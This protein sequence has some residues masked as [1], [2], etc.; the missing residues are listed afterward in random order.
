MDLNPVL[1]RPRP[2]ID[3]QYIWCHWP[4]FSDLPSLPIVS[5]KAKL[6]CWKYH[7]NYFII[8][9]IVS[10]KESSGWSVAPSIFYWINGFRLKFDCIYFMFYLIR[11]LLFFFPSKTVYVRAVYLQYSN[12]RTVLYFVFKHL[13]KNLHLHHSFKQGIAVFPSNHR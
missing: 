13:K 3:N 10:K 12:F 2:T 4:N 11:L 9:K 1:G 7:Y 6:V 5:H 8:E